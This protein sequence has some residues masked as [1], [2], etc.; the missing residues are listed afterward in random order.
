MGNSHHDA[1]PHAD[2]ELIR[3]CRHVLNIED[4]WDRLFDLECEAQDAEDRAEADRLH[5]A[6]A[7]LVPSMHETLA[8]LHEIPAQTTAGLVWKAK[9]MRRRVQTDLD[10]DA[11]NSEEEAVRSLTEDVLRLLEG[12]A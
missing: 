5:K 10:G 8:A 9:V 11:L 12:Q 3:L 2:A 7:V 4:E 6:Q 1:P